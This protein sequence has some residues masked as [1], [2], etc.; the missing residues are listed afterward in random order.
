MALGKILTANNLRMRGIV[1]MVWC[2]MCKKYGENA[3]HF[4][5]LHCEMAKELWYIIFCIFGVYWVM[6][7]LVLDMFVCWK[8]REGAGGL[9]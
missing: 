9:D 3:D 4:F 8:E 6:L 7:N 1:I 5:F 2:F